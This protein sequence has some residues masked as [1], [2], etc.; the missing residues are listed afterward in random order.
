MANGTLYTYTVKAVDGNNRPTDYPDG[1]TLIA[2]YQF[3]P[4]SLWSGSWSG[5]DHT[6]T[7]SAGSGGG[8]SGPFTGGGQLVFKA[9]L[10]GAST[11]SATK[12]VSVS[13]PA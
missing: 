12:T 9:Y 11:P 10:P 8:M 1:T 13:P 5:R 4:H 2:P 3:D 7:L 6:F